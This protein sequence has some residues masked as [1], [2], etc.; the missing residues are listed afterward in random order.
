MVKIKSRKSRGRRTHGLGGC[1]T[2]RQRHVKCDQTRPVCNACKNADIVCKGLTS[3]I[4]WVG[5]FKNPDYE[6]SSGPNV[7]RHLYTEQEREVMTVALVDGMASS[8]V[9]QFLTEIDIQSKNLEEQRGDLSFGPFGVFNLIKS[10]AD[11]PTLE[12]DGS[13]FAMTSSLEMT[14]EAS[15]MPNAPMSELSTAEEMLGDLNSALQWTDIFNLDPVPMG[16]NLT[17]PIWGI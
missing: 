13:D 14:E 1:R 5:S 6:T 7:R 12:M 11:S 2:C 10:S 17:P 4:Q 9:D 3:E 15:L 8:S 16:I